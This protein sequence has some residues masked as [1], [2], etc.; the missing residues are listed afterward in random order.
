MTKHIDSKKDSSPLYFFFLEFC[1]VLCAIL[2][3]THELT[4]TVMHTQNFHKIELD[5]NLNIEEKLAGIP[6]PN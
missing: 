6:T 5:K 4:T 1:L 3:N 2:I